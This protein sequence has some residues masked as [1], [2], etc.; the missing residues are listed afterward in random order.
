[1]QSNLYLMH[2]HSFDACL[3]DIREM[4]DDELAT[5]FRFAWAAWSRKD[6]NSALVVCLAIYFF[7]GFHVTLPKGLRRFSRIFD[8]SAELALA[9]H[10]I[11]LLLALLLSYD[12]RFAL[13]AI[14]LVVCSIVLLVAFARTSGIESMV[15]ASAKFAERAFQSE[16]SLSQPQGAKHSRQ[17]RSLAAFALHDL[18]TIAMA[19]LYAAGLVTLLVTIAA[20]SFVLLLVGLAGALL[21]SFHVA[22]LA[23]AVA[24]PPHLVV[25]GTT[26]ETT[27]MT[28]YCLREAC[29]PGRVSNLLDLGKARSARISPRADY[30]RCR[31]G[32]WASLIWRTVVRLELKA[33]ALVVLYELG[34]ST[35]ALEFERGILLQQGLVHLTVSRGQGNSS[36]RPTQLIQT[37]QSISWIDGLLTSIAVRSSEHPK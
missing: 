20:V 29:F 25:L 3:R 16:L 14:C 30:L 26:A 24:R 37:L 7:S 6:K 32:P 27:D 2:W 23:V 33:A 1:M 13:S 5:E 4:H 12:G 19:F 36:I 31:P 17:L 34:E 10:A 9:L 11:A 15:R 28:I 18:S 8:T 35:D 22:K 21:A